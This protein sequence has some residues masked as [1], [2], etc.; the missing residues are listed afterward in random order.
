VA[1][2]SRLRPP[3]HT[4]CYAQVRSRLLLLLLF[5]KIRCML[6]ARHFM[7]NGSG[8]GC[9]KPCVSEA[10]GCR[11]C[12]RNVPLL[13]QGML[14]TRA[15]SEELKWRIL[16]PNSSQAG[17]H[18]SIPAQSLMTSDVRKGNPVLPRYN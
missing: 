5:L 15:L 8:Q 7:E 14:R 6:R 11:A 1:C 13:G 10:K 9:N 2:I 16:K 17:S 4:V 12:L 18:V 3:L